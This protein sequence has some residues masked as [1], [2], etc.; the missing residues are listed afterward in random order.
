MPSHRRCRASSRPPGLCGLVAAA[1]PTAHVAAPCRSP[2]P[3]ELAFEIT[4]TGTPAE[5]C[6]EQREYAPHREPGT[7]LAD[8]IGIDHR[9]RGKE[10]QAAA[11]RKQ[12][13]E[14]DERDGGADQESSG[15]IEVLFMGA[16]YPRRRLSRLRSWR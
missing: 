13:A 15:A 5:G 16:M 9:P 6:D 4:W 2:S 7:R 1:H 12:R 14:G 3:G 10:A 11:Q 8:G